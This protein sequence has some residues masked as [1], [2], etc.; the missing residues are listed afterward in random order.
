MAAAPDRPEIAVPVE[1]DPNRAMRHLW[2][3]LAV[4]AAG[5]LVIACVPWLST[6]FIR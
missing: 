3:Y 2:P 6:G 4:L 1:A 5:V